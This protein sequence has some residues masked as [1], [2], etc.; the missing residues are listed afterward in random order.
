[1]EDDTCQMHGLEYNVSIKVFIYIFLKLYYQ[2]SIKKINSLR[3]QDSLL[4]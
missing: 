2:F 3:E 4:C 1:M